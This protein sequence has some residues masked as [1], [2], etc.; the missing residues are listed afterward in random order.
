VFIRA[1]I[2]RDPAKAR[3]LSERKY[4]FIRQEQ[5]LKSEELGDLNPVLIELGDEPV[6]DQ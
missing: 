3:R 2:I 1:T 4:N 6:G 5:L